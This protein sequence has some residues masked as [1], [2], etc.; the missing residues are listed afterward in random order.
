MTSHSPK[1]KENTVHLWQA[2]IPT[3]ANF[4]NDFLQYLTIDE[5][6]RANRFHFPLHRLRFIIARGLL[7]KILK[8]YTDETIAFIYGPKGKPF[9]RNNKMKLQFN[10]SHSEDWVVYAITLNTEI[11]VDVQKIDDHEHESIAK[12]H[13]SEQEYNA[14]MA[15]PES[16][17]PLVFCS[18]WA[19]KEAIVK[20]L[21]EGLHVSL[22]SFA[23]S[24][25]EPSQWI[26]LPGGEKYY[27]SYFF[28][29]PDYQAAFATLQ[30][31]ET[32]LRWQFVSL[33]SYISLTA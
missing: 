4:E 8:L 2:H 17:R 20:A 27:L 19:A 24:V 15:F 6:T 10:V 31:V 25:L 11:G 26:L 1:L 14:L 3:L 30:T 21:G 18:I 16:E 29:H 23:V 33:N 22:Q 12:R 5:V 9:L 13:F 32:I 7:R 28:T